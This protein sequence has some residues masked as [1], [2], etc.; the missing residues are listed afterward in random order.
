MFSTAALL[1]KSLFLLSL[2]A[3]AAA[4]AQTA[5]E[6]AN[7]PTFDRQW[8]KPV[9]VY[10]CNKPGVLALT[11]DDGPHPEGTTALLDVLRRYNVRVTF[12]VV[13]QNAERYPQLIKRMWDE[14]HQIASHTYDHQSLISLTD[15]QVAQ[16]ITRTN[17]IIRNITGGA[18]PRYLR[19][20]FG[21]VDQR[22]HQIAQQQN[23]V[24]ALW[25]LDT[26]DWANPAQTLDGF[27]T[28]LNPQYTKGFVSL[29][30]DINVQGM[31]FVDDA[32]DFALRGG[33][34]FD[35]M[36]GCNAQE[37]YQQGSPAQPVPQPQPQQQGGQPQQP[38]LPGGIQL[39]ANLPANFPA[40]L[41]ANLPAT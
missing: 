21:D 1:K 11:F 32:I 39:P 3:G 6:G 13:G 37:A 26:K 14:G 25:N 9:D 38:Q 35:T 20:P 5:T 28:I 18:S 33:F 23:M 19:P 36:A 4:Q 15:D 17:D 34:T 27:R 24:I 22:V 41:P 7:T 12:F 10:E 8:D 30:H 40:N 31:T 29:Q 16:E 2:I